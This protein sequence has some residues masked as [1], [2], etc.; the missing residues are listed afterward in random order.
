M[1]LAPLDPSVFLGDP[2]RNLRVSQ[3]RVDGNN[4]GW[5]P[6]RWIPTSFTMV[7]MNEPINSESQPSSPEAPNATPFSP[8]VTPPFIPPSTSFTPPFELGGSFPG[9]QKPPKYQFMRSRSDKKFAGICGAIGRD[10]NIDTWIVRVLMVLFMLFTGVGFIL[11]VVAALIVPKVPLGTIE[12]RREK[13]FGEGSW[14]TKE[15]IGAGLLGVGVLALMER[16][17]IGFV[18]GFSIPLVLI[19]AGGYALWHRRKSLL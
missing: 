18:S 12:V 3:G 5:S 13:P 15:I 14:D 10:L 16:L 9:D 1:I 2:R 7:L 6:I 4:Q 17:N 19:G 8:P 11:Y